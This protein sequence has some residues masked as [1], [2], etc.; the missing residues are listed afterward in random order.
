[1]AL[2]YQIQH[3][4]LSIDDPQQRVST[5]AEKML[6]TFRRPLGPHELERGRLRL[7][8]HGERDRAVHR[9]LLPHVWRGTVDGVEYAVSRRGGRRRIELPGRAVLDC[10]LDR[11][12][13]QIAA[14]AA[15]DDAAKWFLLLRLVC[16]SLA[17][18]G[19]S[20][21][22][23]ACLALPRRGG[24]QGV[25]LSA[26]SN[27]GKTTTALALANSGWRLLGDDVT[28]VRP[29]HQGSAVWGFPRAC[30]VRPGT[31]AMLPW[32]N[33]L[34]LGVQQPDGV[35]ALPLA[36]LG[37]RAWVGAPWLEP[38]LIVLLTPPN[39]RGTQV[40]EIDRA[41][42]LSRLGGE[43]ID[44]A[45]DAFNDDAARDFVTLGRLVCAAPACR[46]SVGP[47]VDDVASKLER[48]LDSHERVIRPFQP[49][50][51]RRAA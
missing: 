37:K 29:P 34:T 30:H 48:F 22:H 15:A 28:Y 25:V 12:W 39:R 35:R 20:F 50:M 49:A 36:Q 38:A 3:L 5:L 43:S 11:G 27:T 31:R 8:V 2:H 32:I 7:E 4:A 19:H 16:D 45:P 33:D 40:V 13:A 26:P 42:A 47:R 23:A 10:D 24:W 17:R 1:V 51:Q 21:I 41:E 46:L 14:P 18:G 9:E 44:A 6:S